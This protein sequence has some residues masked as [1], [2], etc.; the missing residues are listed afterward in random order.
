MKLIGLWNSCM[1]HFLKEVTTDV[2]DTYV[3][4]GFWMFIFPGPAHEIV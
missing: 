3:V 4:D 1:C 2:L